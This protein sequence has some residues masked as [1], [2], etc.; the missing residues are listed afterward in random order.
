MSRSLASVAF[1][2]AEARPPWLLCASS[3]MIAKDRLRCS[4][5]MVSAMNGNFWTVVVM[6]R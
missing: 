2:L 3:M 4:L 6:I 1:S 5:P